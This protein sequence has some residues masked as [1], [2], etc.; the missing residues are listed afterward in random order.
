MQAMIKNQEIFL[1]NIKKLLDTK[2]DD[3][4]DIYKIGDTGEKYVRVKIVENTD[5]TM[6]VCIDVSKELEEKNLIKLERD[7]DPLTMLFNRKSVRINIENTIENVKPLDVAALVMFDL[8]NL[9]TTNDTYGHK[10][11]DIYIKSAASSLSKIAESSSILG[12][13]SGDEFVLF[14]FGFKDKQSIRDTMNS[15]YDRLSKN[16]LVFPDGDKRPVSISGGYCGLIIG[17]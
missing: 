4:E 6:G 14:L 7:Y 1:E 3:E 16:L 17:H 12:R 15:F 9:K 8:D 13:R 11:G 2:V 5:S 10:W